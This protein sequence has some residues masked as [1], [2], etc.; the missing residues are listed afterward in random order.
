M[1]HNDEYLDMSV[2][3]ET[4]SDMFPNAEDDDFEEEME[5]WNFD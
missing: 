3:D 1:N 5:N 2:Y 4:L